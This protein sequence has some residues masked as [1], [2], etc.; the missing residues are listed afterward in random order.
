M[1]GDAA[2]CKQFVPAFTP[3]VAEGGGVEAIDPGRIIRDP[4]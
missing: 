4:V 1:R 2:D 3:D